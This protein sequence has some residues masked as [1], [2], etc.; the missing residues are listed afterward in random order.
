MAWWNWMVSLLSRSRG[1]CMLVLDA[2]MNLSPF[3]Y[4]GSLREGGQ[5]PG[6]FHPRPYCAGK[7][8]PRQRSAMR[9]AIALQPSLRVPRALQ[10]ARGTR[11]DS[12]R[13]S[14]E[15]RREGNE[16]VSTC[17]SRWSP[18][19]LNTKKNLYTNLHSDTTL[20]N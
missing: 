5:A 15:E 4:C 8:S 6:L 11:S 2:A 17:S 14:S 19:H 10:C 18:I 13:G 3:Q 16:C 12:L 7:A 9:R 20:H 1:A